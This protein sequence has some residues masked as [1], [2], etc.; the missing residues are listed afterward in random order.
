MQ[1]R[2][3]LEPHYVYNGDSMHHVTKGITV[4]RIKDTG[5][6]SIEANTINN[7]GNLSAE[8]FFQL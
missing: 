5:G 8:P 7:V 2:I 1:H 3:A 4:I 6:F